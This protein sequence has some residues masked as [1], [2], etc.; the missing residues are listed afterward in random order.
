MG[1]LM[2]YTTAEGTFVVRGDSLFKTPTVIRNWD[3]NFYGGAVIVTPVTWGGPYVN[4]GERYELTVGTLILHYLTY[5]A[6][7]PVETMTSYSRLP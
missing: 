4:G 2:S 6:D 7:A 5:P 3:R 1:L